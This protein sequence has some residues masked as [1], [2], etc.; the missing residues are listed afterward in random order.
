[1]EALDTQH[2]T[3][4]E[5]VEAV[6]GPALSKKLKVAEVLMRCNTIEGIL[7]VHHDGQEFGPS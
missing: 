2:I 4:V 7:L 6:V 1:L 3:V 5:A